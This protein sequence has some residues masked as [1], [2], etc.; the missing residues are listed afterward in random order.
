MK[1]K[2]LFILFLFTAAAL[3]A[4]EA[5]WPQFRGPNCSGVSDTAKP[6]TEFAPG[7]NQLWKVAV[8]A[9]VSSPCVWG[10]RIFLT[11]FD[12]GKLEVRCH[13][14]SDGKL[15]WKRDVPAAQLEEFHATEGS[16]AASSC[17]TDGERV[18]SYF[19]S[20][21][22][23]C[24]DFAGKELWR[25]PLPVAQT[26]GSFG[27]GGSPV[28]A[29]GLV[30]VNRDQTPGSSLLAV[31]LKSG[32]KAWETARPDVAPGFGTPIFWK[33]SGADE[34]VMSGSLKLKGYDLKTGAERWSLGGM[35]SFT[36]TTPVVGDGLLFFAGWSPGKEANTMPTWAGMSQMDKN[37][38]GALTPDEVKGTEM[39][40]FFRSL[41]TNRDGKIT[42]EDM[43]GMAAMMAKGENVLVA[44]KPGGKG[45]LSAND[46][47]WK[48]TKGLPYVPSALLYRGRI[49]L[50]KDGGMASSFDAKTGKIFYQQERLDA[51]GSY[52]ASPVAADGRIYVASLNGKVTVFAAGGD[53]PKILHQAEFGERI[54][55]TPALVEN[56]LYLRT[57]TALFA[58][59]H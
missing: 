24:H 32:K 4:A 19:G 35:P 7:K 44:V 56:R 1:A 46:I 29:G 27:S 14:R 15:V 54:A 57:P 3:P 59:G 22:L 36:C 13:A 21:G 25:H 52:Y 51:L 58:F 55:A 12:A 45:E 33:N 43:D 48:Q 26:A 47:A 39:E 20:V 2:N 50:V 37:K 11:A 42:K 41:D 10:D 18:V 9:G 23:V 34:V 8:P 16:P 17:A 53:V 49:Y 38:D 30:L 31:D 28:L 5:W 40:S 6:P